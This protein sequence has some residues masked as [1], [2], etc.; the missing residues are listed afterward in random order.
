VLQQWNME[1]IKFYLL[2][3]NFFRNFFLEKLKKYMEEECKSYL[4]M[5]NLLM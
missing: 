3:N 1:A 4:F 2:C 5:Y